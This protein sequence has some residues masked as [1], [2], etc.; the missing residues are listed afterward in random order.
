MFDDDTFKRSRRAV[1]ICFS[2]IYTYGNVCVFSDILWGEGF[3]LLDW[4]KTVEA[5]APFINPF[6]LP[7]TIQLAPLFPSLPPSSSK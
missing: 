5:Q 6:Y 7:N 1:E 2:E 4:R 3:S